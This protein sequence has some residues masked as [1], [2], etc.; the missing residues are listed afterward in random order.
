M[1]LLPS[2]CIW[3][4]PNPD[5]IEPL[6]R[7]LK[8]SAY[9][10]VDVEPK[11]L[12]EAARKTVDE[13]GLKVSCIALDHGLP[14]GVSWDKD[15]RRTAEA[16]E[17]AMAHCEPLGAAVGYIGQP[18]DKKLLQAFGEAVAGLSE[19]AAARGLRL[20][21]EHV[22]GRALPTARETLAFVNQLGRPNLYLLL[23][24]GHTLISRERAWEVVEAAGARLGYVQLD[25]NDGKR[26][27]HWPLLDGVLRRE[28][29]ARTLAVLKA[30]GY[31]G[32]L[33]LELGNTHHVSPISSFS[34]NHNLVLRLQQA[35]APAK[36]AAAS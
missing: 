9:H 30:S 33:G 21:I 22:P 14:S 25:D 24:V 8:L 19:R 29:L 18:K 16:V 10:Y 32:T 13:L 7:S 17:A 36:A 4:E 35:P 1:D 34:K 26:D 3:V 28:D 5:R 15:P 27:L 6:L 2:A 31:Q 23:D 12:G 20:C 11:T